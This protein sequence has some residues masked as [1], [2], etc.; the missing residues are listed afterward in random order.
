MRRHLPR[1]AQGIRRASFALCELD[2]GSDVVVTRRASGLAMELLGA[3]GYM[4]DH[5]TELWYRYARQ[6]T[7]AEGTPQVQLNLHRQGRARSQCL[8]GLR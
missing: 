2:A 6:L 7:I 5:P 8:V 4:K 3:A 1:I